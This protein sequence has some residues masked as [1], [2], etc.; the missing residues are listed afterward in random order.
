MQHKL[1]RLNQ[2]LKL[3]LHQQIHNRYIR[4][5]VHITDNQENAV[6]HCWHLPSTVTTT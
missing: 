6:H 1:Y 4:L 3:D 5:S 2:V